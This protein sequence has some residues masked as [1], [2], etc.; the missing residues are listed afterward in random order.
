MKTRTQIGL[1]IVTPRLGT[2][3]ESTGMTRERGALISA[4]A[5]A[6]HPKV[7][8]LLSDAGLGHLFPKLSR[9]FKREDKVEDTAIR[10]SYDGEG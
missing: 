5:Q 9:C 2:T 1:P 6:P 3:S 4:Q 8:V 7:P 10:G